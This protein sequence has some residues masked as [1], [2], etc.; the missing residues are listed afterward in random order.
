MQANAVEADPATDMWALGV[1]AFEVMAGKRLFGE[2]ISD[3]E[4]LSMLLG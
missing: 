2:N 1:I 3:A 4:V